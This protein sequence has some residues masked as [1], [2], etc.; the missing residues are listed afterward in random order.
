MA[1]PIRRCAFQIPIGAD[2]QCLAI[3]ADVPAS[4]G[5]FLGNVAAQSQRRSSELVYELIS[6]DPKVSIAF[7]GQDRESAGVFWLRNELCRSDLRQSPKCC[8]GC[9]HLHPNRFLF[10]EVT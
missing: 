5:C 2:D 7:V 4:D 8:E 6:D 3:A 1:P 9:W 10:P